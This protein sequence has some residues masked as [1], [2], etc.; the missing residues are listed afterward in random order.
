MKKEEIE[1]YLKR[2]LVAFDIHIYEQIMKDKQG[3]VNNKDECNANYCW[4]LEHIY[5]VKKFYIDA[6][7]SIQECNYEEAWNKLERI[8][9]ML[10]NLFNN[11]LEKNF[12]EFGLEFI[13]NNVFSFQKLFP[14]HLFLSRESVI[15]EENCSICGKIIT[16]RNR[17]NHKVGKVYMGELCIREVTR[18]DLK[19]IAVVKNPMDK[20]AVLKPQGIE[21]NYEALEQL[22]KDILGPYEKIVVNTNMIMN[23]EFEKCG[24]NEKCPCG[25]GKKYKYCCMGTE[26]EL[27]PHYEIIFSH[28]IEPR[29]IRYVSSYKK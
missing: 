27:I 3:Y 18:L 21:Y 1:N 7:N 26:R 5:V 24:R 14:Y 22:K 20:Y 6:Y 11:M 2:E 9:I 8:E 4:C 25:S 12:I 10:E 16:L 15:E 23:P 29:N 17:C 13:R 19:G 28:R